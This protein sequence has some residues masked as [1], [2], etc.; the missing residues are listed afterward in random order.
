MSTRSS[1]SDGVGVEVRAARRRRARKRRRPAAR[2]H[3]GVVGRERQRR[4]EHR[5]AARCAARFGVGAQPAVGR[6]A[7][8]DADAARAEPARRLERPIEQRL[9]DDAL[10]AGADVGDRPAAAADAGARPAVRSCTCRST[11]VFRPLKLKSIRRSTAAAAD[12]RRRARRVAIG[13]RQPR[14]RKRERAVVARRA[15]GDR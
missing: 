12:R 3:R 7:A 15:R 8:G 4:H 5:Q 13:V 2:D 10:E 14:H 9:D 11:A 6:H 1:G